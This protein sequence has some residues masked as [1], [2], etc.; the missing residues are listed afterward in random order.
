MLQKSFIYIISLSFVSISSL[1]SNT[2]QSDI[3]ESLNTNP[4]I[5]ERLKNFRATQQDLNIAEADYYPQIDLRLSAGYNRAGELKTSGSSDW[6]H[7]VQDSDYRNYESS[8]TFTQNLFNGFGTTHQVDFEDSRILAAAYKYLEKSNDIAFKMVNAYVKVLRT[9]ELVGTARENVQINDSIY[10]KVQ[11]LFDSGLTTDSEVKKIQATLSLAKS[12]LSVQK[13]N[14]RDA[15][16]EYRRVL[17]RLPDV[18]NMQRPTLDITMPESIER[19]A[20]YAIENNPS[21][22]V[23]RYNIKGAESLYKQRKKDYYPKVDLEVSQVFNDHDE[24]GNGFDQADDRFNA[25]VVMTYNLFRGG[26]D[27]ANAQKHISKI[28]QEVEIQRDLKRQ[29]V[30]GLDLSWNAYHMVQNQLKDLKD[31]SKYSEKTLELYK[32]EYDLGRRSLLD[33]LSA[34]N[35]VINSRSQII[36]AEYDQLFAKYRIL[37]AMGLLVVAVN[38]TADEF[39]SKVNL[40]EDAKAQE[41]LDT[42]PINL[43][44]D[45]DNI[46]DNIDLCDNSLKENNIMPYGCK[47]IRR[48]D[49]KDGVY[50]DKD[51]CPFTPLDASVMSNGCQVKVARDTDNDGV[52]DSIDA[53]N[54]TPEGYEV[55][56]SGEAT[57]LTLSVNFKKNSIELPKDLDEKIIEFSEY[58]KDNPDLKA[59]MVGHTSRTK[60]SGRVYNVKLSKQRALRV[61]LALEEKGVNTNRLTS[62]G[63]GFSQPIADNASLEGRFEN[64]RVEIEII[65]EKVNAGV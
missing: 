1:Y 33:L 50:N 23:S 17:G 58:L 24:T 46:T 43:D 44:V 36:S 60:V 64:R 55:N 56:E 19:A 59:H 53:D 39:T 61:L 6:N 51:E 4:V 14:A 42:V 3:V 48:D 20:L 32:E 13:N 49:D 10:T 54:Q 37:D 28:A 63:K 8:L 31:Y 11:A 25:R 47:K 12:N 16:Y 9:N 21:L 22:L 45:S 7:G 38:G 62:T 35:D 40:H 15:E 65:R 26:A 52:D 2:L 30:E 27:S 5:L 34:Q 18:V 41:I 57:A 29:V